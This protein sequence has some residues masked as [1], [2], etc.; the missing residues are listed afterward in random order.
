[1]TLGARHVSYA[2]LDAASDRIAGRLAQL[3]VRLGDR[4]A[5]AAD[6]SV[7]T[8]AAFLGTLKAGATYVPLD[9]GLPRARLA[10][11]VADTES[12]VVLAETAAVAALPPLD[13]RVV[14]LDSALAEPRD[15]R[16]GDPPP[17][18]SAI[19]AAYVMYTS[20]STGTPK[21]VEVPHRGVVRLACAADYIDLGPDETLLALAPLSF[22]ASTFEIWGA[23]LNGGRL[24][25]APP[26][27]F[28]PA[29]IAELVAAERVTTLFLTAEL[30]HR[31]V[32]DVPEGLRPIQQL[33]SGGDVLSP[34]HV[35]RALDAMSPGSVLVNCYGPTENTAFT[36][37]HRM[38]PG[39]RVETPVPIGRPIPHTQAHVLDSSGSPVPNGEP[40]ELYAGGDGVA[41]GYLGRAELTAERFPPDPFADDPGERMYRT[42]DRVRR[43]D[44]GTLEFLGRVDRQV[45]IRGH[46]IEPGE[47]EVVLTAHPEVERAVVVP[48]EDI[49]GHKRLVAY[50]ALH[51]RDG[52][53]A[54]AAE[55]RRFAIERLPR[56]MVPSAFV[57]VE[58]FP[59]TSNGKIDR[60]ALPEPAYS[61][62]RDDDWR[63]TPTESRVVEA[64]TEVLRVE[65]IGPGDDFFELGGDSLLAIAALGQLRDLHDV[66]LPLAA[67][68]EHPTVTGLAARIEELATT[69]P[70]RAGLPPLAH[71]DAGDTALVSFAQAQACF[72]SEL[73]AESLAYQFQALIRLE[74]SLDRKALERALTEIV[75]RHEVLRTSF[76]RV[77]GEWV[78]RVHPPFAVDLDVVD[79]RDE[80]D[81]G[82]ALERHA[83]EQFRHRMELGR[84][85]LARWTLARVADDRHVLVHVEHHVV[86]DGWSFAL[87]LREL[88]ALYAAFADGL[89]SPLPKLEHRY[90]D[91]AAWQRQFGDS[92]AAADQLAYWSRQLANPPAPPEL[93]FDRPRPARQSFR[94]GVHRRALPPA[95]AGRL[96]A[97]AG[98]E[99]VTLYM[100]AL[101]AFLIQLRRYSGQDD[102]VVGSGLANR[103][104]P[105]TQ[106]LMGMFVNT[107]ALRVD[108]SGDPSVGELLRRVKAVTLG[109]Y[110]HQELPFERVV[111]ALAPA[112]E[113]GANPYYRTLFSFH[114]SP[115]PDLRLP[116]LSIVPEEGQENGSAKADLNVVVI[117]RRIGRSRGDANAGDLTVVW[118]Y[119]SDLFDR[120]TAGRMLEHYVEAL[121]AIAAAADRPISE[122]TLLPE[123]ER[124]R[125]AELN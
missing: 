21:G 59:M 89:P 23:L 36:T 63:P 72:L 93:P 95:L 9:P 79:L 50:A 84:L 100:A 65:H 107:A 123:I 117:D 37:C 60:S 122:L 17:E 58:D 35:E 85:P 99:G 51:R 28:A 104:L 39:E 41:R 112:R 70:A 53:H 31:F 83:A 68:F 105:G 81:P 103:R 5:V 7:E 46:R 69:S 120:D 55:L 77:G 115:L 98:A 6:R 43:R 102:L 11:M 4:V 66:E 1:M 10:F 16:H 118:E 57:E 54:A 125:L 108:L 75:R 67:I 40:G 71:S 62:R 121:G 82:A 106:D 96:R 45:K 73:D 34:S 114:D 52:E 18:V 111:N 29:E 88:T 49:P 124:R 94:G 116:G 91:F 56:Y 90:R 87:F 32:D 47:I 48:R 119:D 113:A 97:L 33:L 109:A 38:R 110:Q 64:W 14:E 26:T 78:Q 74:G 27:P 92:A 101:T 20:G 3:G 24:V 8:I 25:V 22:D 86:H 13:A 42:G 2:E 76:P 15:E 19:D 12:R 44:D 80:A 30:F 61:T